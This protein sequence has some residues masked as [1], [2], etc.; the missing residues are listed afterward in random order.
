M[1]I[2]AVPRALCAEMK[3]RRQDSGSE[4]NNNNNTFNITLSFIPNRPNVSTRSFRRVLRVQ[5]LSLNDM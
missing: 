3:V 2:C 4:Q 5:R 1:V